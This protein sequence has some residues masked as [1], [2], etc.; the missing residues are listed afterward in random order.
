MRFLPS[1][2]RV[3]NQ[4]PNPTQ[5]VCFSRA[6]SGTDF[7]SLIP[8]YPETETK[9]FLWVDLEGAVI[10]GSRKLGWGN[11]RRQMKDTFLRYFTALQLVFDPGEIFSWGMKGVGIDLLAPIPYTPG[12]LM[13]KFKS[14]F[15]GREVSLLN[16][17]KAL[18]LCICAKPV[19]VCTEMDA[20]AS[21]AGRR[22]A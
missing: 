2:A 3:G 4:L 8:R 22:R 10:P 12:L 13:A 21:A 14:G 6:A 15:P 5:R 1:D 11:K 7:L 9:A 20:P 16:G 17:G 18:S 19:K